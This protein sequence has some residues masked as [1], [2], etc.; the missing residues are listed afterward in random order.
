MVIYH[1]QLNLT[2]Y[3]S[4]ITDKIIKRIILSAKILDSLGLL[5]SAITLIKILLQELW[6]LKLNWDEDVPIYVKTKWLAF[7]SNLTV[8]NDI[9]NPMNV[10]QK[11]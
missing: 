3:H 5:A 10:L 2:D 6:S 9:H 11:M 4:I 1:R 8:I 7:K